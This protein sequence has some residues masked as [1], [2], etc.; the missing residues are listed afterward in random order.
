MTE[1]KRI[2]FSAGD[3]PICSS[4]GILALLVSVADQSKLFVCPTCGVA[5]KAPPPAHTVDAI[6]AI[7][8]AAPQGLRLPTGEE[9]QSVAGSGTFLQQVDFSDWSDDLAPHIPGE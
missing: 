8:D 7:A 9:V 3:C 4:T 1:V 2:I 5:W 6:I